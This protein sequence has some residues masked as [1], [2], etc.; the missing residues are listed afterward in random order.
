MKEMFPNN[1]R[2]ANLI[3]ISVQ[4]KFSQQAHIFGL[5]ELDYRDRVLK[6]FIGVFP[7]LPLLPPSACA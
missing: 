7:S 5:H 4:R 2:L 3:E 6:I 1:P